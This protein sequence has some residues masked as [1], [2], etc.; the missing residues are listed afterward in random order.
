[1]KYEDINITN[2]F[3]DADIF[4]VIN[5]E[6]KDNFDIRIGYNGI[7]SNNLIKI[8][9]AGICA[10]KPNNI[11]CFKS[12]DSFSGKFD[13]SSE[14]ISISKAFIDEF[15]FKKISIGTCILIGISILLS[16]FN[17][18]PFIPY[19]RFLSA[20][21]FYFI[22]S[23]TI[24]LITLTFIVHF[25]ISSLYTITR[26]INTDIIK[27]N[28]GTNLVILSWVSCIFALFSAMDFLLVSM[29]QHMENK[30]IFQNKSLI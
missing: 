25:T 10:I 30:K 9:F 18:M 6:Y 5:Q 21:N 15:Q 22:L 26:E 24:L 23:G 7:F 11:K 28:P 14:L 2:Y 1:M 4:N 27:I 8:Y 17:S 13:D 20:L 16:L 3:Y 12:F 19:I 29:R